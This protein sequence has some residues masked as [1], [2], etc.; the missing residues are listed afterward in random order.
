MAFT[1]ND[2][3]AIDRA[4]A[5]GEL[6]IRTNDRTVTY[7]SMSELLDA[8]TLVATEVA[9]LTAGSHT[10]PRHQLADFSDD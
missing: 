2:L 10:A 6:T 9:K 3:A 7:R 1:S 4:I 5:S 8:R